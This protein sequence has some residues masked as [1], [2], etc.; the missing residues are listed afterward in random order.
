VSILNIVARLKSRE[1]I[2]RL[3]DLGVDVLMIDTKDLTTKSLFPF[4][5]NDLSEIDQLIKNY[6]VNL[7]VYVNK[8]IHEN[9][10]EN[11]NQWMKLFKTVDVDGIVI[12]DFTVYVV[13]KDH[14]LENKVIY[15]PGT[16]NTN[17]FDAMFLEGKIKGMTLS[18][19]ITLEEIL[20][21]VK[22][23]SKINYSLVGHGYIDM[24]Y[25]KRKL[26][27]NYFIHKNRKFHKI[28]GNHHF[29]LEEKTRDNIYY[30]ILE[31]QIG[32][33]IFR[34]KKLISFDEIDHI[35]EY[36]TDFFI[37]RLF[38]DDEEYYDTIQAY[39]NK[40][41]QDIFLNRY[42]N[43]NNGFYYLPTEKTKGE[44]HVD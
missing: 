34:D 40:E 44:R 6:D 8:M 39:Q 35:K 22:S 27:T 10:L 38:I 3:V 11:L 15:Q 37:E 23:P 16:M 5:Q 32:T 18:K 1:E 14:G 13:A 4:D 9:D 20:E 17:T 29:V 42:K 30:P 36:I 43:F 24:F 26:I 2:E 31:D 21:I 41:L 12:N 25:S 19:E 33:H 7:Y 28:K